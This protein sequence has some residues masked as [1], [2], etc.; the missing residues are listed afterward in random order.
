MSTEIDFITHTQILYKF[1]AL[2]GQTLRGQDAVKNLPPD[3]YVSKNHLLHSL[4]RGVYKPASKN[5]IL[6]YRATEDDENYGKQITWDHRPSGSFKK[7]LMAPPSRELDANAKRDIDALR[8][9]MKHQIPIG[10]LLRMGKRQNEPVSYLVMGLGLIKA[11][12]RN[13]FFEIHPTKLVNH[14]NFNH[15][16][17]QQ[18]ESLY[19]NCLFCDAPEE[20]LTATYI[21]PWDVC[22]VAERLDLDNQIHLCNRH[23]S[24]FT[25]GELTLYTK[26]NENNTGFSTYETVSPYKIK[27]VFEATQGMKKYID[28]H[29]QYVYK[30]DH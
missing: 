3:E 28:Y 5:Y 10:L 27:K 25:R 11:E 12:D 13:G 18:P 22:S 8:Y 30:N 9:N 1:Q 20:H 26:G 29:N 24:A 19:Q 4:F 23:K 2:K 21:K 16:L 17:D 15:T 7:I 6:S 14:N